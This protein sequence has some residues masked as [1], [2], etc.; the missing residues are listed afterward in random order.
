MGAQQT[1]EPD[2]AALLG[3]GLAGDDEALARLVDL[4]APVVHVRVARA[5]RRRGREARGRDLRRDLE[6][7][8]QEVFVSLFDH[9][10]RALRAWDPARGLHFLSFVG[11]LSER[12]VGMQMRSLKRNPWT[13]DPLDGGSLERVTGVTPSPQARVE[14]RDLLHRIIDELQDWLTPEGRSYFQL[15]YVED[16]SVAEVAETAGTTPQALYAWKN[17]LLKKVRQLR[18]AL[19]D[20]GEHGA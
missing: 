1:Q 2:F 12:A 3:A 8:N 7:L 17:R 11:L 19:D 10:G 15:L 16:K 18:L 9:G 6:D 20:G 13:E 5:L 4:M 14:S